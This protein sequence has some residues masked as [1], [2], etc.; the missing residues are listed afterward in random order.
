MQIKAADDKQPDLD[1]LAALLDRPEVDAPT[2]RR[3]LD[4]A[5]LNPSSPASQGL[6]ERPSAPGP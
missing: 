3:G 5:S 1:A 2:R 6:Q 4:L